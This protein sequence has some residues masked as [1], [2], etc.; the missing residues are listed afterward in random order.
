MSC[1]EPDLLIGSVI[2]IH[3]YLTNSSNYARHGKKHQIRQ[4]VVNIQRE[5]FGRN[6][7]IVVTIIFTLG[8][9]YLT[10]G[11]ISDGR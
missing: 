2:H 9:G 3:V 6:F 10:P 1:L 4:Q 8:W 7:K 11:V 5:F